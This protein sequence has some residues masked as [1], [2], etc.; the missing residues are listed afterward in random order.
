MT[1]GID[2]AALEKRL[3]WFPCE[4]LDVNSGGTL[5]LG[6][7]IRDAGGVLWLVGNVFGSSYDMGCGCESERVYG[8][9]VA[10]LSELLVGAK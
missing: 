5:P 8:I 9:E 1:L 4:E 2:L 3:T 7:V 10:Y 6:A